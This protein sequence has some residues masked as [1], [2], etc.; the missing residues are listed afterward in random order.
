MRKVGPVNESTAL[1]LTAVR[2]AST[3]LV[4]TATLPLMESWRTGPLPIVQ[5]SNGTAARRGHASVTDGDARRTLVAAQQAD[6]LYGETGLAR[7]HLIADADLQDFRLLALEQLTMP[8]RMT[9]L[10]A[11]HLASKGDYAD[12]QDLLAETVH[13]R[14]TSTAR[15]WAAVAEAIGQEYEF[16]RAPEPP[17]SISFI[18]G[19]DDALVA[20]YALV[21][22]TTG[23]GLTDSSRRA[24]KHSLTIEAID[25]SALVLRDGAAF[26][27][28]QVSDEAYAPTLRVLAHSVHL[29]ALLLAM[30]QRTLIDASSALAVKASLEDPSELVDLERRHFDFKRMYWRTSLTVKRTAPSD[31]V[32]REFQ[33]QLLTQM[34]VTDVEERVKD[35]ARLAQSL[36]SQHQEEAQRT[37]NRTVQRASVIIGAFGV[38][39]AAAPVL[40]QPSSSLFL[41]AAA[42]GLIAMGLAFLVLSLTGHRTR[43]TTRPDPARDQQGP[44]SP[45]DWD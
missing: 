19:V 37:L 42:A 5:P 34:D 12:Y 22:A 45:T 15:V 11:V 39:F 7:R 35:G 6:V 29:D 41:M 1:D 3:V 10:L 38:A 20:A 32:L 31:I 33:N 28:H 9:A 23:N 40:A 18:D 43:R 8:K 14:A 16:A 4:T 26:V 2:G 27:G 25:W 30:V 44:R 13:S 21:T 17:K 24:A 36:H